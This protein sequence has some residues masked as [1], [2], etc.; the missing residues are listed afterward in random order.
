MKTIIP[1]QITVRWSNEDGS[2]EAAVTA[3]RGCLAYGDSEEEAIREVTIAANVWLETAKKYGKP[4]PTA[5][6]A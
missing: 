2:Y 4:I 3:L 1:Y 6:G 5:D